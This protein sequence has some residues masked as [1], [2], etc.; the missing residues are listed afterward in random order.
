MIDFRE[1]LAALS[2][3]KSNCVVAQFS[4]DQSVGILHKEVQ[5]WSSLQINLA[6]LATK[7][8]KRLQ[9]PTMVRAAEPSQLRLLKILCRSLTS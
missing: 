5:R 6:V 9:T 3:L 4:S 1:K 7:K 8:K 2:K